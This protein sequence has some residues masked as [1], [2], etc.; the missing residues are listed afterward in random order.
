MKS[1]GLSNGDFVDET[2]SSF[3]RLSGDVAVI[4]KWKFQTLN[5]EKE[6]ERSWWNRSQDGAAEPHIDN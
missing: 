5:T 2:V 6:P 4:C 3:H 1:I